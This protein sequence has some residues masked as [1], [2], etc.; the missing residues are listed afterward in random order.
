MPPMPTTELTAWRGTVS[1][2][3][4]KILA[5]KPQCAAAASATSQI[6][7]HKWCVS[8]V[9][10]TGTTHKAQTSRAVFREALTLQPR[11]M[12]H[13]DS[14]PPAM[15]PTSATR[16]MVTSGKLACVSFRPYCLLRKSGIQLM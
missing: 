10:N 16:K 4:V 5:A 6:E 8:G 12:S 13:D 2:T 14:Q 3:S 9:N 7:S 1:L 11:R 15:P